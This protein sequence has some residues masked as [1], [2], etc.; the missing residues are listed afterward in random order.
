MIRVVRAGGYVG[1]HDLCWRQQPPE[2]LK[3]R[4]AELE[5]EQPE[6]LEGWGRRFEEAGLEEVRIYDKSHL[7]PTWTREFRKRLGVWG[8]LRTGVKILK[9]WGIQGLQRVLESERIFGSEH[10]GY[11]LIVGRKPCSTDQHAYRVR[12]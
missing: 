1:I 12:V 3:R 9:R 5:E 8:Y 7:I 10:L 11:S 4:L 6:T 2:E